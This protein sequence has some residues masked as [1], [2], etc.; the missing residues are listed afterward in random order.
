MVIKKHSHQASIQHDK[1]VVESNVLPV[2]AYASMF[3]CHPA[4][5]RAEELGCG[6]LLH[7]L[8][9]ACYQHG[10]PYRQPA[11]IVNMLA[12]HALSAMRV[13]ADPCHIAYQ[14]L[15]AVVKLVGG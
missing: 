1:I 7:M 11:M 4:Q 2:H 8:L 13:L 6:S 10:M 9:S 12:L 3:S 15:A 5:T 14:Q